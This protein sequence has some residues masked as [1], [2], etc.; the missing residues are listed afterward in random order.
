[1]T[2]DTERLSE[3]QKEL[4]AVG[5]SVGAGCHPCVKHHIKA[6][7][8]AGVGE[9]R[10]VAALT[11]SDRIGVEASK[12]MAAHSRGVL[13]V[14]P[15]A[16]AAAE[17]SLD[18]ALASFGAAVAAND[19]AAI[20]A[21][22]AAGRAAGASPAQLQEAVEAAA[23][24][25]E[26]A[27]RIHVRE[28]ERLVGQSVTATDERSG[29]ASDEKPGTDSDAGSEEAGCDDDCP[30]HADDDAEPETEPQA[31]AEA[32]RDE[33]TG[34]GYRADE[35]GDGVADPDPREEVKA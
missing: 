35:N 10:L 14:E 27:A 16:S 30:C 8:K 21:Q 11:S 28:A 29:T 32:D 23:T 22:V 5:A 7:V 24:V 19:R 12:R 17:S 13:G 6:A 4:V 18:D 3:K 33:S 15:T 31:E 1:M 2:N 9:Q 20:E 26:N 25:Q 34:C